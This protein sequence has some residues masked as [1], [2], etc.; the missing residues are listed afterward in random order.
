MQSP[1][2]VEVGQRILSKND[3]VAME[4]RAIYKKDSVFVVN[5]MSSPG[6]GKTTLLEHIAKEKLLDFSVIEGD[7][8]TNRDA[9]RLARF[10]VNAYQISTGEACHL[11]A[12]MVKDALEKLHNQGDLKGFMFIENV[13][14]LVC[15]ASY[16]LGAN[17]NIVLLSTPE[18]DDK[19]LKYPTMFLCA[20]V[21][22]V[23]KADLME[24]FDF[25]IERVREDLAKLKKEIPLF[26]LSSKNME[27]LEQFCAFLQ[28]RKEQNYVSSHTF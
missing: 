22:V 8:Q 20:D 5:L 24:V 4:L 25:K 1:K 18:G 16:D 14:N 15:P 26:L 28:Q 2:S 3:K 11:E 13:G 10:G 6:S 9:E 27:S 19:V 21:V 17:M 23:S 12:S 7:L